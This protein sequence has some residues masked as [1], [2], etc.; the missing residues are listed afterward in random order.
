MDVGCRGIA[1]L[2]CSVVWSGPL[3]AQDT[4]AAAPP[5]PPPES[6]TPAVTV[7]PGTI[8]LTGAEARESPASK[9]TGTKPLRFTLG[10][11][12]SFRTQEERGIVNNRS[13]FRLEYSSLV[14]DDFFVQL[15]SKLN[16][17]WR[18]DHRAKAEGKSVVLETSTPEAFVQ[19]SGAGGSTSVKAGVQRLI[20]GESE[21]GA[22]T[23][24]VSP[25]NLSEL[26]FIPLEEARIGQ[27][28]VNVE[29]FSPAGNWN[30][31]YVP[32]PKFNKY[33][34][35]GTAY[36]ADPF[37]GRANVRDAFS[38]HRHETGLRWKRTFSRSDVSLMAA[39]L[40]DNDHV[41]RLDNVDP[42]GRLDVSRTTQRFTLLGTTFNYATGRLLAKGEVGWKHRK[43]FNDA[44][45]QV[46]KKDVI[47]ASLGLTYSLGQSNTVGV[48][49]VNSH[50]RDWSDRIVGVPRNTT[51]LVLNANL[52]FL[53]DQL[54][55]N[56]LAIAVR[57][58]KSYQSS[59][60]TS[61][62]WSDNLTFS[63]DAHLIHVPDPQSRLYRYRGQDQI[64]FRVQ[65]QF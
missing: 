38:K 11:E 20:W 40:I 30:L 28:M 53:N 17:Y 8:D 5:K 23:D 6:A 65:H 33:P 14:H 64:V 45:L 48:E 51:S 12:A 37:D 42:G 7:V 32:A 26:F 34:K 16:S 4:T 59:I 24:E 46:L 36:F 47:D 35:P 22:V 54:S 9:V 27:F 56:L 29:H 2:L 57:P 61:Y 50:L 1:L 43:A 63:V 31:F 19:Y 44:A 58:F 3:Q 25:R 39:S 41:Y 18:S 15:D 10:H 21:A 52:F 60:R 62:K 49:V 55:V 13:W